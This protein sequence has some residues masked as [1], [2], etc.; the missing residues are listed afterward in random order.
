LWALRAQLAEGDGARPPAPFDFWAQLEA[1]MAHP[2]ASVATLRVR[3]PRVLFRA[4]ELAR[5]LASPA[6][7]CVR[8][9]DVSRSLRTRGQ[10]DTLASAV[11]RC[12]NLQA[13]ARQPCACAQPSAGAVRA[14]L[15]CAG[16]HS[17][18]LLRR[19]AVCARRHA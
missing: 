2:R 1:L 18:S 8:A 13:R 14:V 6:G 16:T 10:A 5:L 7:A 4:T 9:L 19:T 17:L 11:A 12:P 15:C 3:L